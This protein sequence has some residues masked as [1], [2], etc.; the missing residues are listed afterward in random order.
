MTRGD[1]EPAAAAGAPPAPA[2]P[3]SAEGGAVPRGREPPFRRKTSAVGVVSALFS[4]P[5]LFMLL[6]RSRTELFL[7]AAVGTPRDEF[8]V[9]VGVGLSDSLECPV[10]A[11]L[12]AA[13]VG[14]LRASGESALPPITE[15]SSPD[16]LSTPTMDQGRGLGRGFGLGGPSPPLTLDFVPSADPDE[17]TLE[18]GL[19]VENLVARNPTME[20]P[21]A[22]GDVAEPLS[23]PAQGLRSDVGDDR[24]PAR[25]VDL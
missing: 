14:P 4:P 13:T 5:A 1:D 23:S 22:V 6:I 17:A 2:E 15:V 16:F 9:D 21:L 18:D 24:D 20:P 8:P 7:V 3:S 11:S 25:P 10:A 12:L 19:G